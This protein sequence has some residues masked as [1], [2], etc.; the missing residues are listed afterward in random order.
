MFAL[1]RSINARKFRVRLVCHHDSARSTR[2]AP[3]GVQTNYRRQSIVRWNRLLQ[4]IAVTAAMLMLAGC[5][6]DYPR[7]QFSGYVINHTEDEIV[8]QVGKPDEVDH[9]NPERPIWVYYKNLGLLQ[10]NVQRRRLQQAR[11]QDPRVHEEGAERQAGRPGHQLPVSGAFARGQ[12]TRRG[13][14]FVLPIA[15]KPV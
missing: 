12:N 11:R 13:G 14:C 1:H 10:E 6:S 8:A 4:I 15:A 5:K 7:G 3:R 9:S 2:S